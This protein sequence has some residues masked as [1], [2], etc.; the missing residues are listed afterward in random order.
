MHTNSVL[1]RA[2]CYCECTDCNGTELK[3]MT[4]PT[5]LLKKASEVSNTNPSTFQTNLKY[6]QAQ[7]AASLH[8]ITYL[9][10]AQTQ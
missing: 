2:C 1:Q 7:E 9:S 10:E 8:Y 5:S 4:P 6:Q 3:L